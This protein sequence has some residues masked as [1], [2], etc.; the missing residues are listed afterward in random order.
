MNEKEKAKKIK[1]NPRERKM[2]KRLIKE[3]RKIWDRKA[4]QRRKHYYK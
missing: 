4:E 1:I 3:Q 2:L